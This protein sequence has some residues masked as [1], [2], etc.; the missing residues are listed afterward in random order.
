MKSTDTAA[1]ARVL[2]AALAL[3]GATA[4]A[5][6]TVGVGW[7]APIGYPYGWGT[8]TVGVGVYGRPF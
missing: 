5:N 3:L 8:P 2:L 1:V 4:C 6:T 7:S